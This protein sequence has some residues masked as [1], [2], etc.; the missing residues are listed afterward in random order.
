MKSQIKKMEDVY[1]SLKNQLREIVKLMDD[2]LDAYNRREITKKEMKTLMASN[3][4]LWKNICKDL[5]KTERLIKE[6][7]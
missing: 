5:E 4:K 3:S 1:T 7:R 2:T 6:N